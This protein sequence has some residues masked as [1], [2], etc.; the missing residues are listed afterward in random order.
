[1]KRS[2]SEIRPSRLDDEAP[3]EQRVLRHRVEGERLSAEATDLGQ[4]GGDVLQA[5]LMGAWIGKV[6][7]PTGIGVDAGA[8]SRGVHRPTITATP[9]GLGGPQ[10]TEL[11][12]RYFQTVIRCP[13]QPT[14]ERIELCSWA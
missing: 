7:D 8:G 6:E 2:E 9:A 3:H 13:G 10:S 1:M 14:P 5:D 12:H 4:P 11:L